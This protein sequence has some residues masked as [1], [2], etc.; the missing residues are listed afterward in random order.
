VFVRF[1]SL[2]RVSAWASRLAN[3]TEGT[4]Y[5]SFLKVKTSPPLSSSRSSVTVCTMRTGRRRL[6]VDDG[7]VQ[8]AETTLP[9]VSV[10]AG[11]V[12][13]VRSQ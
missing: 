10:Q 6:C 12:R 11:D 4:M 7:Q 9:A 3:W 8:L 1:D 5:F 13:K 2:G